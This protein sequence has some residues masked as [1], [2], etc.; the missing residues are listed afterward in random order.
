MISASEKTV[1]DSEQ[2]KWGGRP[3]S[4]RVC[5]LCDEKRN[6]NKEWSGGNDIQIDGRESDWNE[7]FIQEERLKQDSDTNRW[8]FVCKANRNSHTWCSQMASFMSDLL[9]IW[10]C[11]IC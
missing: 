7:V 6:E 2:K 5:K 10:R 1:A 4:W 3:E 11:C 8:S 9:I